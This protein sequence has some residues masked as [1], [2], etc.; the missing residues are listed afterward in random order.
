MDALTIW[1]PPQYGHPHDMDTLTIWVYMF[2]KNGSNRM[3]LI[4]KHE[5]G[6]LTK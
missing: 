2:N 4:V 3:H 5:Q 1:T 6:Y